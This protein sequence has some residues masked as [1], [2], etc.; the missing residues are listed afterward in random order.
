M[1]YA[2]A[3]N[4]V[5]NIA[6]YDTESKLWNKIPSGTALESF[7]ENEDQRIWADVTFTF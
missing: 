7:G 5:A 2:V 4:V 6:Y 3:K 1:N